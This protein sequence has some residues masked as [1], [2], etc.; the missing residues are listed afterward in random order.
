MRHLSI[1]LALVGG[2]TMAQTPHYLKNQGGTGFDGGHGVAIGPNNEHFF[3]GA[4]TGMA[5]MDP[6]ASGGNLSSAGG[7]DIYFAKFTSAGALIWAKSIGGT[8]DDEGVAMVPSDAGGLYVTGTYT[9][10]ADMD[11]GPGTTNVGVAGLNPNSVGTFFARYTA[12]GDLIWARS[13]SGIN[14]S[15]YVKDMARDAAGNLYLTG[16]Y[17]G[18][19]DFDPSGNNL[20]IPY[21]GNNADAFVA[22][23]DGNGDLLW[24][25]QIGGTASTWSQTI[26]VTP[27]GEVVVGGFHMSGTCDLDPGTGLVEHTSGTG[28]RSG[29]A[30]KLDTDGQYLWSADIAGDDYCA[31]DAVLFDAT[32]AVLLGG[33]F[34]GTYDLDPGSAMQAVTSAGTS[35]DGFLLK[36]DGT[37]GSLA[38]AVPFQGAGDDTVE[39]MTLANDGTIYF[40]GA[41]WD[42]TD[43]DPGQGVVQPLGFLPV[44]FCHYDTDLNYLNHYGWYGFGNIFHRDMAMDALERISK[45]PDVD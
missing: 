26:D 37:S 34:E 20:I 18:P 21:I 8:S 38:Q 7:K 12:N 39:L 32:G 17:T 15:C 1:L 43:M 33:S 23:Y 28:I 31:I 9:F 13:L 10:Q 42:D 4:F 35:R 22:K 11:P 41:F 29:W 2:T 30:V 25:G 45:I 40:S 5:D 24:A 6:D 27:A 16:W 36:L 44:Y 3:T 19:V 14:A